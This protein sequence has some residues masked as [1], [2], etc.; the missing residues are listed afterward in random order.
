M[1]RSYRAPGAIYF[2]G[3]IRGGGGPAVRDQYLCDIYVVNADGVGEVVM[4][5][6]HADKAIAQHNAR[7]FVRAWKEGVIAA[8]AEDRAMGRFVDPFG[9]PPYAT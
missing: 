8:I 4:A 1:G 5:T 7:A 9:I 3:R 2:K 6:G